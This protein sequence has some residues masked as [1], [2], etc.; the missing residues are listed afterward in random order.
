MQKKHVLILL[1]CLVLLATG[2]SGTAT[3]AT[4]RDQVGD[5]TFKTPEDAITFYM[6]GLAQADFGKVM[7]ACAINE[8]SQNFRFDLLYQ[9][10][11]SYQP[12]IFLA[13]PN[14]PFNV[15]LNKAQLT[16]QIAFQMKLFEFSLLS[17]ETMDLRPIYN[18]DSD[19]VNKFIND[20][21]STRL[22]GIEVQK[23]GIPN[24]KNMNTDTYRAS[25]AKN[26]SSYG[27]DEA[28]ERVALFSFEQHYYYIGFTLMRYGD[29]W[30]VISQSSPI[31][32]TPAEGTPQKTTP[33]DFDK[34]VSGE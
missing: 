29:N 2:F 17:S 6:E 14:H 31:A 15:E 20:V 5:V 16:A 30:K 27:A 19:R 12:A 24:Q 7:Q 1:A 33:D 18:M 21:N 23:I 22:A 34:L 26:A 32:G 25:S 11:N 4:T 3:R 9:R 10:L 13:P 8:R 28:T